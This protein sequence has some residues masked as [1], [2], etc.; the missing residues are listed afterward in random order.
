MDRITE[1]KHIGTIKEYSKTSIDIKLIQISS[2]EYRYDTA[3]GNPGINS[4]LCSYQ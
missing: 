2:G 4:G 1:V 3:W